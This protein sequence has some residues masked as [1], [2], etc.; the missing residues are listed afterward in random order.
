MESVSPYLH[1]NSWP[2]LSTSLRQAK[3]SSNT[4]ILLTLDLRDQVSNCC[5]TVLLTHVGVHFLYK[6]QNREDAK[7]KDS[8]SYPSF[9]K[10][11]K[12]KR[13]LFFSSSRC[14]VV[15]MNHTYCHNVSIIRVVGK[16]RKSFL[17]QVNIWKTAG[18]VN[19]IIGLKSTRII[20]LY[21]CCSFGSH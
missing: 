11:F 18:H 5:C 17:N 9:C 10:V 4:F 7:V 15:Y 8:Q 20:S 6:S 19:L 1:L 12:L 14:W 2:P 21:V 16:I 13:R 3:A